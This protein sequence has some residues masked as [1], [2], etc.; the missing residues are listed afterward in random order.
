MDQI[1]QH[2]PEEIFDIAMGIGIFTGI[3]ISIVVEICITVFRKYI[4]IG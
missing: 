3:L 2:S 4:H 1:L